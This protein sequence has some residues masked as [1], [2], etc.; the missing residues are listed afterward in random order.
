MI[1]YSMTTALTIPR[2]QV[3]ILWE[4]DE[5]TSILEYIP[6]YYKLKKYNQNR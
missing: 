1:C 6:K 5:C 3:S 2:E 4:Y